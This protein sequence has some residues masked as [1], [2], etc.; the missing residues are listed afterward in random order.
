MAKHNNLTSPTG[1]APTE[2]KIV[3]GAPVKIT[4]ARSGSLGK[5]VEEDIIEK[6]DDNW[7]DDN[8]LDVDLLNE[9]PV[10]QGQQSGYGRWAE[11]IGAP[12]KQIDETDDVSALPELLANEET[13]VQDAAEKRLRELEDG[14]TLAITNEVASTTESKEEAPKSRFDAID[15]SEEKE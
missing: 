2:T 6:P 5:D 1:D 11:R 4:R 15:I 7:L 8:W 13:A 12:L 10:G 9:A 3:S 14:I